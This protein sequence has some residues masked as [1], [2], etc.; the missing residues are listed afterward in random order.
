MRRRGGWCD[1][2]HR[3]SKMVDIKVAEEIAASNFG[4]C[5]SDKCIGTKVKLKWE[6][7]FGHVW[8]STL[9][10]VKDNKSWCPVCKQ[11]YGEKK[12]REILEKIVK[13]DF[14][15]QRPQWLKN[16]EGNNLE[17]DGYNK[18]SKLGFEYQG[19]QHFKYIRHFFKN[20]WEFNKRVR[21]D[22][23]K[24]NIFV[25]KEINIMFPDYKLKPI[26]FENFILDYLTK[27]NLNHLIKGND[28]E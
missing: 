13:V 27:N 20:K 3:D 16:K 24:K 12:F 4:K 19:I 18:E 7:E 8:E 9:G 22:K 28:N 5:L 21:H 26:S 15:K 17:I 10:N 23:I 11:S 25:E 2:C 6:C 1:R 14:R